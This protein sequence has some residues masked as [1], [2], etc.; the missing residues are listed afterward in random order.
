MYV[1]APLAVSWMLSPAQMVTVPDGVI[2]TV[3]LLT[4]FTVVVPLTCTGETH[5]ALDVTIQ[6][7]LA[8]LV[9]D[10]LMNTGLLVPALV[11]LTCH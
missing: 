7:T 5:D 4:T 1:D 2:V 11:P 8:P 10:E 9:S 6:A 3:G